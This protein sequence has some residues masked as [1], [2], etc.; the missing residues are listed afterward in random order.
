MEKF[1]EMHN[2]K[3]AAAII[4]VSEGWWRERVFKKKIRFV[5]IGRRILI[6]DSTISDLI[7]KGVVEPEEDN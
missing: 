5:R 4:N 6:P 7:K 1:E 3:R 2:I